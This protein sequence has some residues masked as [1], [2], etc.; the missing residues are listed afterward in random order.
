M[1]S[2]CS[3]RANSWLLAE[4]LCLKASQYNMSHNGCTPPA[5]SCGIWRGGTQ[6]SQE[7]S[8]HSWLPA[9]IVILL[10]GTAF[11]SP[12]EGEAGLLCQPG[13]PWLIPPRH[14]WVS[15]ASSLGEHRSRENKMFVMGKQAA[16][17]LLNTQWGTAVAAPGTRQ[18][19]SRGQPD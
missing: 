1:H 5:V 2:P 7:S 14:L 3:S 9:A 18:W 15:F 6:A 4:F 8:T 11:S 10:P 16:L 17:L 13:C 12:H 19:K